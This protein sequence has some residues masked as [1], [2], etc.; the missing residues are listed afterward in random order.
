MNKQG[1]FLYV[2]ESGNRAVRK[3]NL[4]DGLISTVANP[5]DQN[6][7]FYCP[8][9]MSLS[10]DETILYITDIFSDS[11]IAVDIRNGTAQHAF[12]RLNHL[13]KNRVQNLTGILVDNNGFVYISHSRGIIKMQISSSIITTKANSFLNEEGVVWI[14]HTK[15][16]GYKDGHFD[17]CL[18]RHP[19]GMVLLD[20]TTLLVCDS[21]NNVLRVV[22]FK[23]QTVE[24]Y[25]GSGKPRIKDGSLFEA[26]FLYP[27]KVSYCKE[28]GLL[29]VTES[30]DKHLRIIDVNSE[31]VSTLQLTNTLD[32][33]YDIVC[34]ICP[35]NNIELYVTDPERHCIVHVTME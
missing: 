6:L 30:N 7:K 14:G 23:T 10:T 27:R 29:F 8:T 25:C 5:T 15:R 24:T 28:K 33:P 26:C 2:A 16:Q 17:S 4:Q 11:I 22:D 34:T 12:P 18:F 31:T 9:G 19:N 21:G 13:I 1:T 20:E 32:S 35:S 3:I